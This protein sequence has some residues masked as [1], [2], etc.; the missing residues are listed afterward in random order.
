MKKSPWVSPLTKQAFPAMRLFCFP[1]SGG[2]AQLYNTWAEHLPATVQLLGIQYPGRGS[3]FTETPCTNLDQLLP[4]L[5]ESIKPFLD[6]PFAFFGHSLGAAIAFELTRELQKDGISPKHLF[7]SARNAPHLP[8]QTEPLHNLPEDAFRK[9][10]HELGGT[11]PEVLEH[12]ELMDLVAPLIR[13]DFTVSETYA[14][15]PGG[16]VTCPMTAM[17]GS[18]DPLVPVNGIH[19]WEQHAGGSFKSNIFDGEHFYIDE[20]RKDVVSFIVAGMGA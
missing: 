12:P 11:A 14:L 1:Y 2:S 3:R 17:G 8:K 6:I 13:A 7:V 20:V 9:K 19:E 10:I 4:D 16:P 15:R 18:K 5:K